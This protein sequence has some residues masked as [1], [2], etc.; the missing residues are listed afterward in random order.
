MSGRR[1]GPCRTVGSSS[2]TIRRA[3]V[4]LPQPDSPT[5]PE[6]LAPVDGQ[7]SRPRPRGRRPCARANT[8]CLTGKCL[9]RCST[10]T[11][12]AVAG[13][14]LGAGSAARHVSRRPARRRS[15]LRPDLALA[16]GRQMAGVEMAARD[17]RERRQLLV[18][19]LEAVLA[20]RVERAARRRVRAAT[21]ASP[22]SATST[23]EPLLDA[24]ASTRAGPTCTGCCA[25]VEDLVRRPVL[26]RAAGVHDHHVRRG[27]GDDAEVVRDQDH[28]DVELL[29]HAVDQ[30]EDL[31]LHGHVERRRRL[32]GD[33]HV[34]VVDERHRDHRALAHAARELVR[35]VARAA[36]ARSGSRPRRAARRRARSPAC[37]E[38]FAC[39]WTAS[40]IW[41]P[42]R[43]IGCRHA[44]GS[45]KII[46]MS[47]PR[48]LRSSSRLQP[49]AGRVPSK[50]ISP[51]MSA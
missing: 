24:S 23:V 10:S 12:G 14:V 43:Y 27:L 31:R 32:V 29:L 2:R 13:A 39:A 35:V 9:V 15:R 26:H 36:R 49:R 18:A 46:E 34:R 45:W 44:N 47:R 6:R 16:L 4:D 28:A 3:V 21:A 8:P 41:S 42:T 50:R 7:A 30:L 51:V 5:M 38:T 17:R 20:A 1:S 22:R 40:A 48:I 19:R 25:R 11:S 37:F 33:Q